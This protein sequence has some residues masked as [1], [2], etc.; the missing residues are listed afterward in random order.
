MSQVAPA[1]CCQL[2]WRPGVVPRLAGTGDGPEAP[3]QLAGLGIVG[4]DEPADARLAAADADDHHAVER[5]RRHGDR[6]AGRVVADQDLPPFRAGLGVERVEPAIH[7]ADEGL[8]AEERDAAVGRRKAERAQIVG[9]PLRPPPDPA[10]GLGVDRHHG[11]GWIRGVEH[12]AV[13]QRRRLHQAG[14]SRILRLM[15][16]GHAQIGHV[17]RR[18]LVER[19]VAPRAVRAGVGEPVAGL[20]RRRA[21]TLERHLRRRRLRRRRSRSRPREPRRTAARINALRAS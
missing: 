12:A 17:R 6:V 8:V 15:D 10:P 19:R 11:R 9:H 18:D 14:P 7:G 4:V 13:D 5:E 20:A 16:P 3:P 21:E 2:D 1:P